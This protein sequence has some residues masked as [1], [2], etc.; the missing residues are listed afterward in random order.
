[1]ADNNLVALSKSS[2]S[3]SSVCFVSVKGV[4]VHSSG[5][6]QSVWNKVF[7]E[8]SSSRCD[9]MLRGATCHLM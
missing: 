2:L 8:V 4:C 7:Q 1:M 6:F 5:S 9:Y 3:F